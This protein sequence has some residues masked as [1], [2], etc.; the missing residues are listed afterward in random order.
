M[1]IGCD[2]GSLNEFYAESFHRSQKDRRCIELFDGYIKKGDVYVSIRAKSDGEFWSECQSLKGYHLCRA[3]HRMY[4]FVNGIAE[5]VI[6]IGGLHEVNEEDLTTY[7]GV[8]WE[9]NQSIL[10]CLASV[11]VIGK[12][13]ENEDGEKVEIEPATDADW[14]EV[15]RLS[16]EYAPYN[17]QPKWDALGR[18]IETTTEVVS[19]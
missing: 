7:F 15:T 6:P 2:L 5:C 19:Q 18:L 17:P 10:R 16:L 1:S 11:G 14:M 3:L 8:S 12:F 9:H 13:W 4:A